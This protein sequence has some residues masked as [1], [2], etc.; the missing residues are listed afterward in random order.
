[1]KFP[2]RTSVLLFVATFLLAEVVQAGLLRTSGRGS[3]SREF[4]EVWYYVDN[5]SINE[6]GDATFNYSFGAGPGNTKG[7]GGGAPGVSA[8]PSDPCIASYT[9]ADVD[10][11]IVFVNSEIDFLNASFGDDEAENDRI[12]AEIDDLFDRLD[13]LEFSAFPFGNDPCVW[14]FEEGEDLFTFGTF[15]PFGNEDIGYDVQW[16]ILGDGVNETLEGAIQE[17]PNPL[18]PTVREGWVTLNAPAPASLVPGDY[19]LFVSVSL[20]APEGRFFYTS[21]ERDFE[22]EVREICRFPDD[23]FAEEVC[24]F[25]SFDRFTDELVTA[26]TSFSSDIG[27]ILRIIPSSTPPDD[28]PAAVPAPSTFA[29]FLLGLLI[30][31]RGR[32]GRAVAPSDR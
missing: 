4:S 21:S 28:D 30:L 16:S 7:V 14:E 20:V 25:N 13:Q 29:A 24:G 6:F 12:Q 23:E 5:G 9:R 26:R 15:G 32:R 18:D 11:E 3:L 19:S 1:M 31:V 8:V 10:G 22:V 2:H 17:G 27:E